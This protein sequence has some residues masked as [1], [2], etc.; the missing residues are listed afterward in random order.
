[1]KPVSEGERQ[2]NPHAIRE[3]FGRAMA[4]SMK[5]PSPELRFTIVDALRD[6]I[7]LLKEIDNITPRA[8]YHGKVTLEN[9]ELKERLDLL[10]SQQEAMRYELFLARNSRKG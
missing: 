10:E 4:A 1:M 6:V 3:R 7:L 9:L 5:A 2:F 8:D